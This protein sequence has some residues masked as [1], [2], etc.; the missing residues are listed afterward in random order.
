LESRRSGEPADALVCTCCGDVV[1]FDADGLEGLRAGVAHRAGFELASH[2]LRLF[3]RCMPCQ[4][5]EAAARLQ[6]W[7]RA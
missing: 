7:G 3:G 4:L 6:G 2:R 1:S 5:A